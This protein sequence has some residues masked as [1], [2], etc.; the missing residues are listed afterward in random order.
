MAG[1]PGTHHIFFPSRPRPRPRPLHGPL[2]RP[3]GQRGGA[4]PE[5]SPGCPVRYS[6]TDCIPVSYLGEETSP[7]PGE[8]ATIVKGRELNSFVTGSCRSHKL[9]ASWRHR[10]TQVLSWRSLGPS[11][12]WAGAASWA[13]PC[14]RCNSGESRPRPPTSHCQM[15]PP[16]RGTHDHKCPGPRSDAGHAVRFPD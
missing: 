16:A 6:C 1:A 9:A 10:P 14:E 12:A 15:T 11:R 13:K 7:G 4:N 8:D 3:R 2:L 5:L